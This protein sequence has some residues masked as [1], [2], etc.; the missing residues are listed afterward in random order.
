VKRSDGAPQPLDFPTP[1]AAYDVLGRTM[2]AGRYVVMI[3]GSPHVVD[4]QARTA[5]PFVMD[6]ETP[7]EKT[8]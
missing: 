3:A 5:E 6:R 1:E 2:K 7:C 4:A 8:G